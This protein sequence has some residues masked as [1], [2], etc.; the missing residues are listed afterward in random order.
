MAHTAEPTSGRPQRR[1]WT[2]R[3]VIALALIFLKYISDAFE[4]KHA[5]LVA[6]EHSDPEDPEE[7][8][9]ENIFWVPKDARWVHLRRQAKLPTIGTTIDDAMR[10]IEADNQSLR[11]VLPKEYARPALNKQMVGE[12]ID[13]I[14]GIGLGEPEA[15]SKDIPGRVYEYFLGKFANAEGKGGGEFYTPRSVVQV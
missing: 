14:G 2:K 9:A 6:E 15:R 3:V 4:A 7:Y 1:F 5:E 8:L 12:L 13:L 11:G 10:S